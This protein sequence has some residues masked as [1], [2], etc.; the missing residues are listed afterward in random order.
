MA[1]TSKPLSIRETMSLFLEH[2]GEDNLA[3]AAVMT[4]PKVVIRSKSEMTEI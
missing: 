2:S 1:T 3:A 4:T